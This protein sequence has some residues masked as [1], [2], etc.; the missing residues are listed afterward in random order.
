MNTRPHTIVT[1][2]AN[3]IGA[4]I[5]RRFLQEGHAVS[6]FDLDKT[7]SKQLELD[8]RRAGHVAH[9]LAVDIANYDGVKDAV[10]KAEEGLWPL[11]SL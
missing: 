4:A 6:I 3:G 10:A 11:Q 8:A 7:A 2:G 9:F 5:V 1:G